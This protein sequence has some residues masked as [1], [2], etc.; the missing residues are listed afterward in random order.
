MI[1]AIPLLLAPEGYQISRSVR[2][3][4]SASAYFNRT[5]STPTSSQ[6]ATWSFWYKR[7]KTNTLYDTL[8]AGSAGSAATGDLFGILNN[9]G[10]QFRMF[11][12]GGTDGDLITTQLFRDF[13]AWYHIVLAVDTTQATASNRLK[14]YVNG[15]Q[16][17]AFATASY[18]SLNYNMTQFFANGNANRIG[19]NPDT[20]EYLDGYLTEYYGIDG[21]ALTP[22]S[23]G[24]TDAVT[25]VWKPK[26][27]AGTYGTNGFYLN[28][29]D[30]SS[31]TAATIGKDYSGNGN[32]WTPNNISVT[33]GVTYD[34]MLDVP[35]LWADGG[36]GRG[37]YAVLNPL[38]KG[39]SLTVTN[40]NLDFSASGTAS[41]VFA[42]MPFTG[43]KFYFEVTFSTVTAAS[44]GIATKDASITANIGAGGFANFWGFYCNP[45]ANYVRSATNPWNNGTITT[46]S[47][48]QI[49]VDAT[50]PANVKMWI[51]VDNTWYNSS[52]GTT[53]NPATGSNATE[54]LTNNVDF[55]PFFGAGNSSP[56]WS[57]NFGQ[58]PFAFSMPSG[59]K[60]LN[61]LNLP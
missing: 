42:T 60:A 19:Y 29:S 12:K 51:G 54:T 20:S 36:N 50:N 37:N 6:K 59:F 28:F 2:L 45:T 46:S 32:N 52:G 35:T 18:P 44:W 25:G 21:Q 38:Q 41:N 40:G 49:A 34:S 26:K 33:A 3:R 1:D 15:V 56:A 53:G 39:S 43:G 47:V 57:T 9:S 7:G 55:F 10:G 17:T 24:E 22:S 23:F 14:L 8:Y 4:S 61:T 27:Y 5:Q 48:G 58:R 11:F 16:V 30:N 31:N 13:S